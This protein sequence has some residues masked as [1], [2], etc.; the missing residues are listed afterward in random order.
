MKLFRPVGTKELELIKRS[1]MMKFPPR[2]AEQPI[3]YPVLN[4]EYARQIAREWNTK[5]APGY[6]GFVTE[7]DVDS[8]Y[9]SKFAIKTVG[10]YMHQELWVPAEELD[11]FNAHIIGRIK[12]VEAFYGENY[13]GTKNELPINTEEKGE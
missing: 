10:G 4:V 2:L 13:H 12:V 9:V 5:S 6:A 7:F 3:F 1:K 8:D 11:E